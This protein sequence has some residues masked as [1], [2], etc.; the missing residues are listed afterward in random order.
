[1]LSLG[2]A[3]PLVTW[4]TELL[5][6]IAP[7]NIPRLNEARV[8]WL[9]AMYLIGIA[10]LSAFVAGLAPA[11]HTIRIDPNDALKE[12]NPGA[13]GSRK[14]LRHILVISEIA[15]AFILL[16]AAGLMMRT[17][18][19]L[20]RVQP[21][22]EAEQ[23]LTMPISVSPLQLQNRTSPRFMKDLV[24]QI[25]ALPGVTDVGMISHLPLGAA[26]ARTAIEVEGF[27]PNPGEPARAHPRFAT[28]GYFNAMRIR[29]L[30]GRL[31]TERDAEPNA[32]PVLVVNRTAALRYWAGTTPIGKRMRILGAWRE[33]IGIV[34]DVKFWGL[35]ARLDP[36][37]YIPAF[38]NPSNLVVRAQG[39]L[40]AIA[41]TIRTRVRELDANLPISTIRPMS[42]MV[43]QSIASPKFFLILLVI[44]GVM[45]V[46]L[47]SAGIY[48]V[49]SYTVMQNTREIG[50]KI[51]LGADP[52]AVLRSVL[53]Q[54]LVLALISLAI[55]IPS[56]IGL[57]R[58]MGSLLFGV[59]PAD[60]LTFII[61]GPVTIAIALL[62]CYLP[63]RRAAS[64]D[65]IVALRYQ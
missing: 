39:D 40:P 55:G 29:L 6:A 58:L 19:N 24:E 42:D 15:L 38:G 50:V 32:P 25:R 31:P 46:V 41:S 53:R 7:G 57:T 18:W 65:P 54:G 2:A 51:A 10:L 1:M 11:L 43:E 30:E 56:A 28:P 36:E 35:A 52:L 61:V 37:A 60:P 20:S 21:G 34:A 64:V 45:A 17:L 47:A 62:A 48:G 5:K 16:S 23:V 8:D 59:T 27:T 33:V 9:V 44:F 49:I 26:D 63:A 13:G 22:F 3:L 12:N 4:G 14:R